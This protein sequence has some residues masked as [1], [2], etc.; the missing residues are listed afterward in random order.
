MEA[1]LSL[2]GISKWFGGLCAL[3]NI[4]MDVMKGES[5]AIIGPNGAGKTTLFNVITGELRESSGKVTLFG[6]DTTGKSVRERVALGVCRTY[7]STAVCGMLTVAQNILLS[8]LG[9]KPSHINMLSNASKIAIHS[10]RLKEVAE[11]VGLHDKLEI[12]ANNLS[13]GEKRQLEISLVIAHMPHLIMF[14]EPSSGLSSKERTIIVKLLNSF[15]D[16]V[17]MLLI[18]HDMSVAFSTTKRVIVL[19][20]GRIIAEGSPEEVSSNSIVQE[21]YLGGKVDE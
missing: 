11:S 17:G 15:S 12:V 5:V 3:N 4:N 9:L 21:V 19:H 14:D 13:Y 10:P 16:D 2:Q 1:V 6:K 20:E 7:Q 18:E 8:L